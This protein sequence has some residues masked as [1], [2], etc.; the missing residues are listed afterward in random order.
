MTKKE[1]LSSSDRALAMACTCPAC[2]GWMEQ[3][4]SGGVCSNAIFGKCDRQ[5]I[6]SSLKP[7]H[8]KALAKYLRYKD[9]A[10]DRSPYLK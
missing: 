4:P 10:I 9:Q 6:N 2:G 5:R 8:F 3:T 1:A 7:R